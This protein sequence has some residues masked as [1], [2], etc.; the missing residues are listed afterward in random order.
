M[1]PGG[2]GDGVSVSRC[3]SVGRW[4]GGSVWPPSSMLK[5]RWVGASADGGR[6]VGTWEGRVGG[7]VVPGQ[8]QGFVNN[9]VG[10][11]KI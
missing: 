11:E 7:A 5:S 4:F 1:A 10:S 6:R 3:G 2:R 9:S 8:G